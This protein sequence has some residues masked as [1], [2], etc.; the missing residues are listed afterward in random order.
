MS[1]LLIAWQVVHSQSRTLEP[2]DPTRP[3]DYA[4]KHPGSAK[5]SS[6]D[7]NLTLVS[8]DRRIAVINGLPLKTGE[9]VNGYKVNN[10]QL[11]SVQLTGQNGNII[12]FLLDK[13]VK[14]EPQ[15]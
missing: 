14:Q 13:P 7:L 12:L 3:I 11:N 8:S 1:L 6:F 4:E 5:T 10:I 9:T 2:W 15:N